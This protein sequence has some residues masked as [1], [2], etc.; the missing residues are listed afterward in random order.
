VPAFVH[1]F[2]LTALCPLL[3]ELVFDVAYGGNFYAIVDVQKNFPGLEF[4]SADQLISFAREL[5]K[6]INEK[7]EFV[8]PLDPTIRGCTHILW[9]G[10]LIDPASTARN[11]VYY[12][13]KA[14]D[15]SP[16]GTGTSARM[17]Q[18]YS[19][20]MLK[21]GMDFIHES[22]IGSKF[23]GRIEEELLVDGKKAI[24]PSIEGW[25]KVYGHNVITI[26]EDDPFAY[27]FT[28]K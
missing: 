2:E 6:N 7:Y 23:I 14:I 3:G 18:W 20:G 21:K 10:A 28:V 15:R 19:K 12:G 16:C 24:R 25:A 5:R 17:A 9:A 27:G 11:A 8:H 13:E 26:E 4:Y 22:I 1:S